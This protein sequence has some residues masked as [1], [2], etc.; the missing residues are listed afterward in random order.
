MQMKAKVV[1]QMMDRLPVGVLF[2]PVEVS[3]SFYVSH[4]FSGYY[5]KIM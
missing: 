3:C 5:N 1:W 4:D 2:L